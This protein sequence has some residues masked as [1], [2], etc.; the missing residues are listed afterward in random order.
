MV[1]SGS[2]SGNDLRFL[3]WRHNG[4]S[5]RHGCRHLR[6]NLDGIAE[7]ALDQGSAPPRGRPFPRVRDN[8]ETGAYHHAELSGDTCG[9]RGGCQA[10]EAGTCPDTLSVPDLL[11]HSPAPVFTVSLARDTQC[12]CNALRLVGSAPGHREAGLHA[13]WAGLRGRAATV[14]P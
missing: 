5:Y 8:A 14:I 9:H 4:H 2:G 12:D 7:P 6:D 3:T 11:Q 13:R 10:V 1:Q